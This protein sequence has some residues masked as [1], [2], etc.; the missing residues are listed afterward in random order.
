M[1]IYAQGPGGDSL[2]STNE[3]TLVV[4]ATAPPGAPTL[5]TPTVSG[6]NVGLS[7]T[8]GGG[9]APTSYTLLVSATSGGAP[10]LSV[11]L[12]GTSIGFGGVP[13]GT[14]FLRLVA[15]NGLGS[16]APSNQVT[17]VVP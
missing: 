6:N 2:A 1:R 9:G 10:F 11:P 7:W 12:T 5:N 15:T 4:G 17:L 14:Y 3:V 16:S 13:S 8:P